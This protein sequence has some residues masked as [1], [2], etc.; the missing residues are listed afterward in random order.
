MLDLEFKCFDFNVYILIIS[1][2]LE[3]KWYKSGR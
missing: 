3:K 2:F 1:K